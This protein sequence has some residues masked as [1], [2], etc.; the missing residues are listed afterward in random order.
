MRLNEQRER[1][2][3]Y[4]QLE[5]QRRRGHL[6]GDHRACGRQCPDAL[7]SPDLPTAPAKPPR[8]ERRGKPPRVD[9]PSVERRCHVETARSG[10]QCLLC[11]RPADAVVI[12]H[13]PSG[14]TTRRT[15]TCDRCRH[16]QVYRDGRVSL[17]E[18]F[19]V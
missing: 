3:R 6:A 2:R 7:A 14:P 9:P 4:Q 16:S 13:S 8:V 10:E 17:R 12:W 5:R 18:L 1:R 15:P 19:D 11:D